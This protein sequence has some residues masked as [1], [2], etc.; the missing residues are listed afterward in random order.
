M[1]AGPLWLF[2]REWLWSCL[3]VMLLAACAT[4]SARIERIAADAGLR[5]EVVRGADFRHLVLY[6]R[7]E[8]AARR[9]HVYIDHDGKPW[10]GGT[11]V[12]SDPSPRTPLALEFMLQDPAAAIYVGRPCHFGAAGQPGCHPLIWT[13]ARY[14][15]AVVAS[16]AAVIEQWLSKTGRTELVLIGYSGGGTLASLLAARLPQTVGLLTIAANLDVD[17]WTALHRYSP[18]IGSLD[19]AQSDALDSHIVQHHHVGVRDRNVPPELL[20]RFVAKE[21]GARLFMHPD[22]DHVCCWVAAWPRLLDELSAA[23]P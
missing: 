15:E 3:V 12:A 11:R 1:L 18:M 17:A 16:M 8:V 7:D 5:Q 21:P 4:P 9:L 19:P 6:R 10:I 14:G 20:A 22:F 23:L 2:R 13:H